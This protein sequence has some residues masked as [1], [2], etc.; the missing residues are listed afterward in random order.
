MAENKLCFQNYLQLITED[1]CKNKDSY[2]GKADNI[3]LK[4][5]EELVIWSAEA[6]N[7]S[8]NTIV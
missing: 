8:L 5:L 1:F 7:F 6:T 3:F 2:W 4:E